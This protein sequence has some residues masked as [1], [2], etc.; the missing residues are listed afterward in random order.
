MNICCV[1][2]ATNRRVQPQF[3]FTSCPPVTGGWFQ[4]PYN[5][6]CVREMKGQRL[7]VSSPSRALR[8][9]FRASSVQSSSAWSVS[10]TH[11]SPVP[12][13]GCRHIWQLTPMPPGTPVTELHTVLLL[14]ASPSRLCADHFSHPDPPLTPRSPS[15]F[16]PAP[17]IC[18]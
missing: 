18:P 16:T 5:Q 10:W 2:E 7:P 1:N 9:A 17:A 13:W 12:F 11:L 3:L 14:E 8:R 15:G 4:I 6:Q